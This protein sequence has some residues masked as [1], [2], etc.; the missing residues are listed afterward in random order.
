[1]PDS[2]KRFSSRVDNY[3]KYRPRY[4][5]EVIELLAAECGLT[6]SGAVADIGS[7]TGILTEILLQNGNAVLGVEP[8]PEMRE[9]AERLL[10]KYPNFKSINGA[11]EKTTLADNSVDL[12]TAGQAFHWFDQAKARR[13][14]KRVLRP[15]GWVALIWNERRL[16]SSDFLR[17]LEALLVRF[18]TDYLQ[19]RH[20]NVYEDIAAFFGANGF[21]IATSENLQALDLNG[22]E[23]RVYSASYSPELGHPSFESMKKSLLD[24]FRT[25]AEDGKVTIEYDTRIY[26]GQ[27]NKVN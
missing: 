23:G 21:K 1:V 22:L 3:V 24:I 18:G 27:M 8:N 25:Y 9:A 16:E 14:F 12:I 15:D 6:P 5:R 10:K 13:E 7:G 2:I 17:A 4:P 11:A 20:E 19:V 26:Y